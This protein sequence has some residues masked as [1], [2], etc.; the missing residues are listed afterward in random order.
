MSAAEC[1]LKLA[2]WTREDGRLDS[3]AAANTLDVAVD[4]VRRDLDVFQRRAALRRLYHRPKRS[5]GFTC[6]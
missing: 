2:E 1:R 5:K 4:D 6:G 3:N